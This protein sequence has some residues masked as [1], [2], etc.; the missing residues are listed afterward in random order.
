MAHPVLRFHTGNKCGS[1]ALTVRPASENRV[2][3]A[4]AEVFR[5]AVACGLSNREASQLVALT[6]AAGVAAAQSPIAHAVVE[7]ECR[8]M[9]RTMVLTVRARNA[10][11]AA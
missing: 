10:R 2:Q 9:T 8:Q 7:E 6:M 3:E 5:R 11:R 1:T 4:A